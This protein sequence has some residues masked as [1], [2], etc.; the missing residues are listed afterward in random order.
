MHLDTLLCQQLL[1]A[2][3]LQ[4]ADNIGVYLPIRSEPD[5][6]ACYAQWRAQGRRLALPVVTGRNEPLTFRVWDAE[7]PLRTAAFGVQVPE[8]DETVVPDV[9]VIPCV[10]FRVLDGRPYRLG[11]GGGFYDRTLA[12]HPF[13]TVG[14]AYDQ[15]E[16]VS[17]TLMAWDRPLS[18]L[19]TPSRCIV[20][21]ASPRLKR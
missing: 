11:Y 9:L 17:L 16:T 2:D 4:S 1:E 21:M 7:A 19:V 13:P 12:A 14:V 10:G 18:R 20:A 15:A 6:S 8:T 5:L 3:L